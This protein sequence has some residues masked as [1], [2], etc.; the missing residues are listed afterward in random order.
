MHHRRTPRLAL[1]TAVVLVPLFFG[2]PVARADGDIN[3]Q[4]GQPTMPAAVEHLKAGNGFY[5]IGEFDSAIEEYKAGSLAEPVGVFQFNLAQAYRQQGNYE[6]AIWHY[7]RFI[8]MQQPTGELKT[9]ID[10]FLT[11]MRAELDRAAA[12]QPP[13]EP[14]PGLTASEPATPPAATETTRVNAHDTNGGLSTRKKAAIAF[15]AGA[16]LAAT[17]GVFLWRRGEGFKDDAADLCPMVTCD[18]ADEANDLVERGKTSVTYANVSFGVAAT[19]VV[20]GTVLWLTDHRRA[21]R[22][23]TTLVPHLSPTAAGILVTSRF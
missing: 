12:H 14:G 2:V 10:G 13:N 17:A 8:A 16:V 5:K 4:L 21:S 15:G 18:R 11:T 6:K 20:V 19:A 7:E 9:M 23:D 22:R 1:I 3:A